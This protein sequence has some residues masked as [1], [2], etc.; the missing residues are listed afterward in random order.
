[1]SET[2]G[3]WLDDNNRPKSQIFICSECKGIA[4]FP[5]LNHNKDG[6]TR[7][8]GYKFCPNCSKPMEVRG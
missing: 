3:K 4:Y 1:M 8:C 7:K 6:Q 2:K 5:Q